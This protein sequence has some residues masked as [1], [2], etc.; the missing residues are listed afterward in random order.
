MTDVLSAAAQWLAQQMC[1]NAASEA[2]YERPG[3]GY[4]VV[5]SASRGRSLLKLADEFGGV[6]MRWTECDFLIRAADLAP[7]GSPS[8]PRRGDRIRLADGTIYEV[9]APAGEP[10]WRWADPYR[11]ILRIHA[12]QV[13]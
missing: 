4:G 5:V 1:D 6:Q 9:L 3:M 10:E 7:I 11:T 2:I 13:Q 12:K 8:T